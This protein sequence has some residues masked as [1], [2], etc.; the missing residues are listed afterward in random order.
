[1]S[2]L[3]KG[4]LAARGLFAAVVLTLLF[5]CTTLVAPY[6][7]TFDEELNAFSS[8]TAR[9]LAAAKAGGLERLASSSPAAEYYADAYNLLD[10]LSQR[11]RMRRALFQCPSNDTLPT[12]AAMPTARSPLPEDYESFDCR[13]FQLFSVRLYVDQLHFAQETGGTLNGS[14]V[15][16]VGGVLQ[17]A[18]MGA[19]ETSI[20]NKPAGF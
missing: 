5:G 18:I 20:A 15:T 10:R 6:D 4:V 1:M 14:E 8:T 12:F 17:A 3:G 7:S 19:I 16:A 9:Y 11:A 13:E 2:T